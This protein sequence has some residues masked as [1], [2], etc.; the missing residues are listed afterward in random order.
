M[1]EK[2]PYLVQNTNLDMIVYLKNAIRLYRERLDINQIIIVTH[3]DSNAWY[4][5]YT[6][7]GIH[8]IWGQSEHRKLKILCA[9]NFH[10]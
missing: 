9:R 1:C 5:G 2:F 7:R 10:I 6:D 8:I 3:I 4:N